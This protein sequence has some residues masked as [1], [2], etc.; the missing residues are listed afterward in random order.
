LAEDV[1]WVADWLTDDDDEIKHTSRIAK[2]AFVGSTSTLT[3]KLSIRMKIFMAAGIR[4]FRLLFMLFVLVGF[5]PERLVLAGTFQAT[6]MTDFTAGQLYLGT[7]PGLLYQGSNQPPIDHDQDGRLFASK[8]Q[9]LDL[10]GVP[11][12]NG[13]I[14]VVAIGMSNWTME[15]C[16]NVASTVPVPPCTSNS[17]F[18]RAAANPAV[19]HTSLVLIDCAADG[20]TTY[21]WLS[22]QTGQYTR[23]QSILN[24]AGLSEA[25]VQV[26]L[27]K[28]AD[29]FPTPEITLS[30]N[31]PCTLS[32]AQSVDACR[33]ESGV[34]TVA[35]YIKTRY[36]NVKQIFLHSRIYCGYATKVIGEPISYEYAFATKWLI[37]SQIYQ[38]RN[39]QIN[40]VAGNLSYSAAP[41][42]V[43]GPYF[44]ASGTTPRSD[45]LTWNA[46]DFATD[47]IHPS[48]S[49]VTKVASMMMQFYSTS[50][51]S[52]W[53]RA[54]Y[55]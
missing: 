45:G 34:G 29:G 32:L 2:E 52:P 23:C 12:P 36:P 24:D 26:I 3:G 43:W 6:P 22:D 46:S 51:Y 28:D 35:R 55:Q 14:A 15:M 11:D 42:L 53:F 40:P 38:I 13:K 30:K 48:A 7:F 39:G 8:V 41:W 49:G 19:N 17:F 27:W 9:P 33:Y 37:E 18:A 47:G 54:G 4:D 10:N 44:W 50:P 31:Q 16:V 20:R 25:Q 1:S 5:S 21:N